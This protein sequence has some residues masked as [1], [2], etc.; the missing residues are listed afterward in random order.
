MAGRG[1]WTGNGARRH[2]DSVQRAAINRTRRAI[3]RAYDRGESPKT[4]KRLAEMM[5]R[6]YG[7]GYVARYH[8]SRE[9]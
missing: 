5:D 1:S 8:T 6:I 4:N 7:T 3:A 9:G 2:A